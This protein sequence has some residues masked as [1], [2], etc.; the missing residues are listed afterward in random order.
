MSHVVVFNASARSHKILTTPVKYLTDVR[1]EACQKFGV[2]KEQFTLKY[3]AQF[4][5]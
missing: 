1:D 3:A 5:I 2:S 4:S